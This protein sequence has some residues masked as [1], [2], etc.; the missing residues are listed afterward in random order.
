MLQFGRMRVPTPSR[1]AARIFCLFLRHADAAAAFAPRF[2]QG[3][4]TPLAFEGRFRSL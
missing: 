4:G 1:R 3:A 2:A